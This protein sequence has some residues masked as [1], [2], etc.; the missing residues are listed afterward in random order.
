MNDRYYRAGEI[1]A[2]RYQ[3]IRF[4]KQQ[5]LT[6]NY[7]AIDLYY[8]QT[9]VLKIISIESSFST[10]ILD[11][12]EK[13]ARNLCNLTCSYVGKYLDFF[14]LTT[15]DLIQFCL[16]REFIAGTTLD[17]LPEN[18]WYPTETNV[19]KIAIDVLEILSKLHSSNPSVIHRNL[20][21][22]NIIL[23]ERGEIYLVDLGSIER[24]YRQIIGGDRDESNNCFIAPEQLYGKTL[25]ASDLYS[26]SGILVFLVTHILPKKLP[27]KNGKVNLDYYL[28]FSKEFIDWLEINLEDRPVD[29]FKSAAVALEFL[30]ESHRQT[31]IDRLNVNCLGSERLVQKKNKTCLSI[32]I[33]Y[34]LKDFWLDIPPNLDVYIERLLPNIV[35]IVSCLSLFFVLL[36]SLHVSLAYLSLASCLLLSIF[37]NRHQ[38]FLVRSCLEIDEKTFKLHNFYLGGIESY[39]L[40]NLDEIQSIEVNDDRDYCF[41]KTDRGNYKFGFNLK[42]GEI[43]SLVWAIYNFLAPTHLILLERNRKT[44]NDKIIDRIASVRLSFSLLSLVCKKSVNLVNFYKLK[45]KKA[46]RLTKATI[47]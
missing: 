41:L 18:G 20:K 36:L 40:I 25:A 23:N 45:L 21:P 39:K 38:L 19:K 12:F 30:S 32:E 5:Q 9:V 2:D 47:D 29:R 37:A 7:A 42:L 11:F 4:L 31:Y 44:S 26:L 8:S 34:S 46:E 17:K 43:N 1:L 14:E 6:S 27:K 15:S 22:E 28:D 33:F 16:V 24:I 35:K 3:I 13:E 10:E